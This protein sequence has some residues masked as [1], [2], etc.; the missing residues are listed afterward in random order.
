MSCH[1]RALSGALGSFLDVGKRD[2]DGESPVRLLPLSHAGAGL[3][4]YRTPVAHKVLG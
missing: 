4:K 1:P 3:V 2:G